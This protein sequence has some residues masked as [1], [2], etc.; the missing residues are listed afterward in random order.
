[1]LRSAMTCF[2]HSSAVT[3]SL[4]ADQGTKKS[5]SKEFRKISE[6]M[7]AKKKM[8][9]TISLF[10]FEATI[11]ISLSHTTKQNEFA[12]FAHKRTKTSNKE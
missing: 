11:R 4:I 9:R 1:M 6:N 7:R 10:E 12:C 5:D 3:I 8:R 2:Y